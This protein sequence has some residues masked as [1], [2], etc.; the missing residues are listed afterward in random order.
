[1]TKHEIEILKQKLERFDKAVI[2]YA[3]GEDLEFIGK[4]EDRLYFLD[5]SGCP[6]SCGHIFYM[7][8]PYDGMPIPVFAN[9]LSEVPNRIVEKFE[10]AFYKCYGF[11]WHKEMSDSELC[12]ELT[13]RK[14]A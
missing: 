6:F 2:K 14:I 4:Q 7:E 11:K 9:E 13:R 12:D 8:S 10:A 5:V 3:E 1:M